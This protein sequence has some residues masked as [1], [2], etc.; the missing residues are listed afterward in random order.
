[1]RPDAVMQHVRQMAMKDQNQSAEGG[2]RVQF[3]D[4]GPNDEV[5]IP[6]S[7]PNDEARMKRRAIAM[8]TESSRIRDSGPSW[9]GGRNRRFDN[10]G[11]D[12][13]FGSASTS[14]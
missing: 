13:V 6:E 11:Y 1:M 14:E 8:A 2:H 9:R 12:F 7:N 4:W 3:S 5:R 10:V